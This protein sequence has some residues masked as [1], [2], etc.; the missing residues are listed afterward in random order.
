MSPSMI[1][2][3]GAIIV[4]GGSKIRSK[5]VIEASLKRV[6]ILAENSFNPDNTKRST[7]SQ[8]MV[9][10]ARKGTNPFTGATVSVPVVSP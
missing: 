9:R 2:T 4:V 1:S 7:I 3:R 5:K 8:L 6:N 10:K